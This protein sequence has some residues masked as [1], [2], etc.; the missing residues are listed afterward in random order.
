M[1]QIGLKILLGELK[2]VK[3]PK[4][5][6]AFVNEAALQFSSGNLST[7]IVLRIQAIARR[8]KDRLEELR[9]AREKAKRSLWKKNNGVTEGELAKL[10]NA[11]RAKEEAEKSDLGI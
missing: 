10:V 5:C 9:T 2:C 4:D 7:N 1:D 3:L 6:R 11:R 8:Y